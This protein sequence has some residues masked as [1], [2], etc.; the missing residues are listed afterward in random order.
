MQDI[1]E[2]KNLEILAP[3]G[4][5]ECARAALNAGADAI[6][7]GYGQFSAR[8]SAENF[9]GDG[10][11]SIIDEAHFYG[12]KVYVA[13]NTLVKDAE[14]RSFI[15]TL[16]F[17]W[18]LGADAIILQDIFLGKVIKRTYPKIILHLSTQAGICNE[19]GAILAKEYG[20][21]R[22]ILARETPLS[23]IE[24]ITKIIETEVFIQGALCT[25][26]SGQCYFS[27]FVGGQSGNRGRCK[28]PCRKKYDYDRAGID[29]EKT[30]ALS[31][32]DLSVGEDIFTLAKLGVKSFKI[33][34]RMRRKEYV[35]AATKYYVDILSNSAAEKKVQDLSDLKRMYN[36]G[37]YTKG[38][39]FL[40]DKRLLSPYVQGHIGEYIGTI[41]VIDGKY[42]VQSNFSAK[43]GD[44]FKILRDKE[45]VGGATLL[46][47]VK[48]GLY[49][50]SKTRLKNGD[51][52][53][54]TTDTDAAARALSMQKKLPLSIKITMN[55][56]EYGV[57]TCGN[58]SIKTENV[59]EKAT[60]KA[61]TTEEIKE[62]FLKTDLL[63]VSLQFDSVQ[64]NGVFLPKS[65]LNAFRRS[66]YA[67]IVEA[68]TET[69]NERYSEN[70]FPFAFTSVAPSIQADIRSQKI[71][72][73]ACQFSD[74]DR[75]NGVD[76]AILKPQ[77][78][79][80]AAAKSQSLFS[81]F[82]NFDGEKF[83]YYPAYCRA[84]TEE[85]IAAAI[86]K[87]KDIGIYAD[88]YAA[89]IFARKVNCRLFAG[90]G[91]N[92]TNI[93][94]A[95]EICGEKIA[96]YTLS[97]EIAKGEQEKI[98]AATNGMAKHFVLSTGGIKLMDLC[99]CPFGKTCSKCDKKRE[100]ILT[101]EGERAFPVHRYIDGSGECRFE[102]YNCACL[103]GVA[104][105]NAGKIIDATIKKDSDCIKG[106]HITELLQNEERQKEL[107]SPYT[108]GHLKN[109]VL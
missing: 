50:F 14:M 103:V 67:A 44:A 106:I 36:R 17:V 33:E 57:A 80:E 24:K 75:K 35:A 1:V 12:A 64:T 22:V 90:T 69:T 4:N 83:L 27:S 18:S 37:D 2:Q 49:I 60:N 85:A 95:K 89:I 84:E 109:S 100:Y 16:L 88:S 74:E 93:I 34:G 58:V 70:N 47:S 102:I 107:F 11:K 55:A 3:A 94:A 9:D 62:C 30:Y 101:D 96:Y 41:K 68:R 15:Q 81:A 20:F 104:A 65:M 40:Q 52:V 26:F 25:C 46:K 92:I 45:E 43:E 79:A 91:F 71:A 10:M 38:L 21:S 39:A 87:N 76:I 66:F 8:A 56:G 51:K 6:Y 86:E 63:P 42:F 105:Q 31:L 23:E 108:Y 13:M 53:F 97:K 78:Y 7:L 73:I 54:I 29:G 19:N 59:L 82:G 99:Y 32:S 77:T 28:Q 98:I 61:L 5:A 72:K 48:N